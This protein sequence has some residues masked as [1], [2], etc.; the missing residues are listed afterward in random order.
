MNKN[1]ITKKILCLA[2]LSI[3]VIALTGCFSHTHKFV[4]GICEC[5]A[6]ET[7]KY[8][9]DYDLDGG[10]FESSNPTFNFNSGKDVTLLTPVKE[11]YEFLGWYEVSETNLSNIKVESL[12]NR[13]YSLVGERILFKQ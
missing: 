4:D 8:K 7:L 13:N 9:I 2:I 5:G 10:S 3:L 12:E 6:K 11:G 1:L